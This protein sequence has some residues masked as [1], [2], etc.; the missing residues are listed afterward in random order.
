MLM[1]YASYMHLVVGFVPRFVYFIII[2][3]WRFQKKRS[4]IISH[5]YM[6]EWYVVT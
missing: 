4:L 2:I 5:M 6:L 1:L 3:F